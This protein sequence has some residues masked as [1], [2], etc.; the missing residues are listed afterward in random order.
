MPTELTRHSLAQLDAA[1]PL[2]AFADRFILPEN[3]IYL[4]GNS[5]GALPKGAAERAGQVVSEEWGQ[6]LIRSWN[7]AGWFDLPLKLGD[8]LGGDDR[9]EAERNCNHRHHHAESF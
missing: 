4:D 2:T 6:G 9:R 7:T 3:I 5:L 1:D 8:K